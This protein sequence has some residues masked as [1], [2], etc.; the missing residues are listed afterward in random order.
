VEA[1]ELV[2]HHHGWCRCLY[3]LKS[4]VV[5]VASGCPLV[6]IMELCAMTENLGIIA[7]ACGSLITYNDTSAVGHSQQHSGRSL[8]EL[9]MLDLH[10]KPA[11]DSMLI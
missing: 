7:S 9:R 6:N 10:T 1:I 8:I 4:E 2:S 3:I 11:V 5:R